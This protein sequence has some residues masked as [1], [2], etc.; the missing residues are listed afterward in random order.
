MINALAG[1][2]L[3]EVSDPVPGQQKAEK[4]KTKRKQE[5]GKKEDDAHFEKLKK[6]LTDWKDAK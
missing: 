3:A 1:K 5:K 2:Y 4:A 6:E